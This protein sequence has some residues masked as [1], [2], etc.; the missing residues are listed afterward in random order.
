MKADWLIVSSAILIVF[1]FIWTIISYFIFRLLRLPKR[2]ARRYAK[3][4][5]IIWLLFA[6]YVLY[7]IY[8]SEWAFLILVL[9]TSMYIAYIVRQ[10]QLFMQPVSFQTILRRFW[11]GSFVWYTFGYMIALLIGISWTFYF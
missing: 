10:K 2:E 7:R 9:W 1:P 11:Q 8:F 6:Q 3:Q 5:T 4:G